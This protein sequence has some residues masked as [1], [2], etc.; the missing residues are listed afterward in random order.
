M[1][2]TT[3][4]ILGYLQGKTPDEIERTLKN[5]KAMSIAQ[6]E[7]AG[8]IAARQQAADD[9]MSLNEVEVKL[10][11]AIGAGDL[12]GVAK[13]QPLHQQKLQWV[14]DK[15][16]A[17]QEAELA[18]INEP[19]KAARQ[20]RRLELER[21]LTRLTQPGVQIDFKRIEVVQKELKGLQ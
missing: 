11:K 21:E 6:A 5:L 2:E 4:A 1:A 10:Q 12:A 18:R 20:A 15:L 16:Q 13:W 3:D 19:A 14:T 7:E 17:D 8:T 9:K